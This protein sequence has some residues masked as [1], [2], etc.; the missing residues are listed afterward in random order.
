MIS[1][2]KYNGPS[3]DI[4]SLGVILYFILQGSLPFD[5]DNM[6]QTFADMVAERLSFRVQM[7]DDACRL[8][9]SILRYAPN[10]RISLQDIRHNVWV[11]DYG[12]I[13]PF[14]WSAPQW[15][16]DASSGEGHAE[17][18]VNIVKVMA[19][20][21]FTRDD[22]VR[23]LR[24]QTTGVTS[25]TYFLLRDKAKRKSL[26]KETA[27]PAL[28]TSEVALQRIVQPP[29]LLIVS[30]ASP[31]LSV[32]PVSTIASHSLLDSCVEEEDDTL[33]EGEQSSAGKYSGNARGAPS[34]MTDPQLMTR[35]KSLKGGI[36]GQKDG[37]ASILQN[38]EPSITSRVHAP[39]VHRRRA[40]AS[41]SSTRM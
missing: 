41:A 23:N 3:V 40:S 11:N 7:S 18:D 12:R 35:R 38:N 14:L 13:E 32:S 34:R 4:W 17:L 29:E 9:Q 39:L 30:S 10:D 26:P 1:G 5:E 25:A 36:A 19:S 20:M 16:D 22:I 31:N 24:E 37:H 15:G 27:A 28:Q 21:G 2:Q 33:E 8:V 6:S